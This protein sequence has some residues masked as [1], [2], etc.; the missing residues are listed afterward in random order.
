MGTLFHISRATPPPPSTP[1]GST[2]KPL[3]SIGSCC[4]WELVPSPIWLLNQNVPNNRSSQKTSN[5]SDLWP[6]LLSIGRHS[7][8][9]LQCS[10]DL[11][12]HLKP[13]NGERIFLKYDLWGY[14]MGKSCWQDRYAKKVFVTKWFT[15]S[16]QFIWKSEFMLRGSHR[17]LMQ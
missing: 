15:D 7:T 14:T 3:R 2:N 9:L 4:F 16:S 13:A 1:C 10:I 11:L 8:L 12:L 17:S 6:F 5:T